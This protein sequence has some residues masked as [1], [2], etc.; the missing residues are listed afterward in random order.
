MKSKVLSAS[1]NGIVMG[2]G[3]CL[4]TSMMWLTKLDTTYLSIGQ[5]LDIAI[6][7]LPILV[8]SFSIK[9]ANESNSL[10]IWERV[11]IAMYVGIISYIIYQP[12]LYVYHHF[13]NP[14]WFD[15]VLNLKKSELEAGNFSPE[16]IVSTLNKMK[17]RNLLQDKIYS[18]STFLASVII[19]PILISL[20]S[21]LYIRNKRVTFSDEKDN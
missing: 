16:E 19:L 4:Y 21:L 14:T 20:L 15:A 2:I 10:K 3:F 7:L 6:I 5:Y 11:L 18:I 17:E 8:I 1:K 9:N 13:I 12:F